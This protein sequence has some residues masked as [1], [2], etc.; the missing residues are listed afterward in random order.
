M[1]HVFD[2]DGDHSE[3]M[4][5]GFDLSLLPENGSTFQ[6]IVRSALIMWPDRRLRIVLEQTP[7]P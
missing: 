3:P 2:E 6:A 7:I 4:A 1:L 5:H